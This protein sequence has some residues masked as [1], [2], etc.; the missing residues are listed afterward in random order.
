MSLSGSP[1]NPW[2]LLTR[3]HR[4]L[5]ILANYVKC[6]AYD[7]ALLVQCFQ[8]VEKDELLDAVQMLLEVGSFLPSLFRCC[9]WCEIRCGLIN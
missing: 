6:P 2:A 5:L 1:L 4:F 8:E 9:F 7:P 3:H